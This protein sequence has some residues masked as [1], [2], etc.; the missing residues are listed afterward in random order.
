MIS[1]KT[2]TPKD[3]NIWCDMALDLWPQDSRQDMLLLFQEIHS[4]PLKIIFMAWA[5]KKAIG[6]AF[7]SSRTDYVE[8]ATRYPVGYLEGI[9]VE[10]QWRRQTVGHLL[11][12][13]AEV[14]CKK[15]GYSEFASD[16]EINNDASH[17]FHKELGFQEQNR[18]ICY[19]KKLN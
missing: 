8:G 4:D 1:I 5:K 7:L 18:I 3:Q 13:H 6:F 19:C 16:V 2:A 17:L 10:P 15:Q 12:E 9:Y 11:L 14:W